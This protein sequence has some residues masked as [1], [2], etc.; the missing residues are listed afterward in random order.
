[1]NAREFSIGDVVH[2]TG[3]GEATLRAWER[4]FGFPEPRRTPSGHRRY[5]QEDVEQIQRVIDERG[6]GSALP[7][8]IERARGASAGVPSL[9]ARLRS[10]RPDLQPMRVRKRELVH[11]SHAIEDESAAHAERGI[12]IGSFQRERF[13]RQAEPRWSELAR[14]CE[15]A[16]VFADFKRMRLPRDA[17]AELPVGHSHPVSREWGLICMAPG[18]AACLVAWEP[19]G[20][21][22]SDAE[23]EFELLLSVDPTVVR[24]AAEAAAGVAAPV[25]PDLAGTLRARLA[26][27]PAPRSD[28]QLRLATAITAR[29]L[30]AMR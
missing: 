19:P 5:G 4:R 8:A 28:S 20:R 12:L 3:V 21:R 22:P 15:V 24:E 17:A 26:D 7:A 14:G 23:R 18:H 1:M 2:A 30:A 29:L 6:R 16:F 13:Y 27:V 25:A 11:L 10:Q 9:F